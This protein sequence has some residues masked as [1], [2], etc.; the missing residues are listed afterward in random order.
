[1]NKE[2][3][4]NLHLEHRL[5]NACAVGKPQAKRS[6]GNRRLNKIVADFINVAFDGL[7]TVHRYASNVA[8]LVI[9]A[10]NKHAVVSV[11]DSRQLI[12]H[13]NPP[14]FMYPVAPEPDCLEF[15]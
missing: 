1:M 3:A 12:G 8:R 7:E 5:Q 4:R 14:W 6:E 13:I 9:H 15:K 11:G 10:Q 2:A